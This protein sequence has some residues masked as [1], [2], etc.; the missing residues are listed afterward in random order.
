MK[1]EFGRITG[2]WPFDVGVEADADADAAHAADSCP[3]LL[4]AGS[5]KGQA[6]RQAVR[7]AGN[8]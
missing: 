1:Q 4:G 7:L 8:P 6:P 2:L 5:R 3:A